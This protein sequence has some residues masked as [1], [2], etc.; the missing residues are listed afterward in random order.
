MGATKIINVLKDDRF[1]ELLGIVKDT[2]ASEI[3]FVLPKNTKAFKT[4][5]HFSAL[6]DEKGE[7]SIAFLCSNSEL[8]DLA[9]K[10]N[11][12]VL[13]TKDEP[14]PLRKV[15]IEPAKFKSTAVPG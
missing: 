11:F 2:D 1:E 5:G 8:N 13:S 4:E 6:A 14:R 9:K 7:R 15:R 10:Y 3:I 12:D